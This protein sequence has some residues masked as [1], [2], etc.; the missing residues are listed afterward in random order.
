[1]KRPKRDCTKGRPPKLTDA[2]EEAI[3]QRVAAGMYFK[4]ACG[5]SG[6]SVKT[7]EQWK[8]R[9]E[10]TDERSAAPRY[11]AFVAAVEKAQAQAIGSLV[12]DIRSA[13]RGGQVIS[14]RTTQKHGKNGEVIQTF[15]E[16]TF[17]PGQW[18]TSMTL[19]ERMYPEEYGRRVVVAG[20]PSQPLFGNWKEAL[21]KAW[22][23]GRPRKDVTPPQPAL[24]V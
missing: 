1:M 5:M 22:D 18:T 8:R 9:G 6:I 7:A 21:D 4:Y 24:P 16:E 12:A 11:V 10:G 13:G 15:T 2:V 14:R 20:D 19:L 23:A 3:V 17:Q